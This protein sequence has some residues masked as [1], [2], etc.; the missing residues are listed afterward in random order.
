MTQHD[1]I[2]T[3]LTAECA[4]YQ[5]YMKRKEEERSK[6]ISSKTKKIGL[7]AKDLAEMYNH[8]FVLEFRT[9]INQKRSNSEVELTMEQKKQIIDYFWTKNRKEFLLEIRNAMEK[10]KVESLDRVMHD[11]EELADELWEKD[12]KKDI[13]LFLKEIRETGEQSSMGFN[14]S[15]IA[16]VQKIIGLGTNPAKVLNEEIF[17]DYAGLPKTA[18]ELINGVDISLR[19]EVAENTMIFGKLTKVPGFKELIN[20]KLYQGLNYGK[21]VIV[22]DEYLKL[23][24]LLKYLSTRV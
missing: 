17:S 24:G 8:K 11:I 15:F 21:P 5:V 12:Q 23:K 18:S 6:A 10:E 20:A 3:N 4:G 7:L 2:T 1:E 22:D 16:E 19:R 9:V 14:D 13:N